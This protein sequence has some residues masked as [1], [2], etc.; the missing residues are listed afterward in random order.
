MNDVISPASQAARAAPPERAARRYLVWALVSL[1][2]ASASPYFPRLN[3]P[4]ENVRVWMTRAI[5]ED[6]TLAIDHV[7]ATWGFVDDKAASGGHLYSSKAPGTSLLGVPVL[8]LQTKLWHLAG[9]PSPGKAATTFG[10]RLLSVVP[11]AIAFLFVFGRWV[12]RRTRS[13]AARDLLL[14]GLGLGTML[15]PYG[16]IFVGH[17]QGAMASFAAFM[18]LSWPG[19][20]RSEGGDDT[21][22]R[23]PHASKLR[24][25][26]AGALA[27]ASVMFEYQLLLVALVLAG[28]TVWRYRRAA[29]WFAA[30]ALPLAIALG[31]YHAALFGHPWQFPYGHLENRTYARVDHGS[32][33]FG[34]GRPRLEALGASLFSVSYGVFVFSP[35]LLVGLVAAAW[36]AFSRARAEALVCLLSSVALS[37]FLAGMTHWRAGWCVGPRYVAGIAPFLAGGLALAW[38]PWFE[39]RRARLAQVLLGGL[40]I[41]SVFLNGVSAATYPHYPEAFDNPVFDLTLPLWRDGYVPH[42]LGHALG[43]DRLWALLPVATLWAAAL[44]VALTTGARRPRDAAVRVAAASLIAAA[45]LLA[46]SCYGRQPSPAE[47]HATS[48]IRTLWDPPVLAPRLTTQGE[49][50]SPR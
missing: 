22:A 36:R 14:C 4:N 39:A 19:G 7:L 1:A 9:W 30:G 32:G 20:P 11:C 24:L 15:Y 8:W 17:A 35:F 16:V 41:V 38:S 3:N 43:L 27:G 12:E 47:Q 46:L 26:V 21:P 37:L 50:A 23:G 18:A 29:V 34:L 10:L 6:H 45:L 42:G 2:Y 13:A 44:V 48:V 49:A 31:A 25:A 33:F 28:Y 5:V 40:I